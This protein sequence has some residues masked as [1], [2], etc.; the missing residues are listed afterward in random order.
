MARLDW[1]CSDFGRDVA[2]GREET[3]LLSLDVCRRKH[4]GRLCLVAEDVRPLVHLR[5][6]CSDGCLE[7]VEV[8]KNPN[9]D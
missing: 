3:S 8:A 6:L 5:H 4:L 9:L 7:L 1:Q 2:G